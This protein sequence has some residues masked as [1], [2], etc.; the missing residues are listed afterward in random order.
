MARKKKSRKNRSTHVDE[1]EAVKKAPHT[2]VIKRGRVGKNV[3]ELMRDFRHMMEPFTA[4]SLK[5]RRQNVIR[6][7]VSV[8]SHLNVT[9]LVNFTKTEKAAYMRLCRMP[10]GPTLTY[11]ILE[12]TLARDVRHSQRKQLVYQHLFQLSPLIVMNAFSGSDDQLEV[13]LMAS[14]WRNIFPSIDINRANLNAIRR[15]VLL[16]YNPDTKLI[17]LRH[18]AIKLRPVGLSKTVRRLLNNRKVPDLGRLSQIEEALDKD[19]AMTE[20]EGE[21]ADEVDEDRQVTLPQQVSSRGNMVDEKSAIRLVELG[22]RMTLELVKVEE[23]LMTGDV[24][25]HAIMAKTKAEVKLMKTKRREQ[26][27]LKAQRRRQQADNV[28]RKLVAKQMQQDE[29]KESETVDD[30]DALE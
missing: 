6:D 28:Q 15:V 19:A 22:P 1:P 27:V 3:G 24:L 20:S 25:Y 4:S 11:K 30:G 18:Y 17:D 29:P 8:A 26:A 10:K 21:G 2:F 5:V 9:H 7:F 14:M 16:N 23:G 13:K 12:Y